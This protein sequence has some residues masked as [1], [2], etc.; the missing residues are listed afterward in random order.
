MDDRLILKV[1]TSTKNELSPFEQIE[2]KTATYAAADIAVGCAI[3]EEY[4][5][6]NSHNCRTYGIF[7]CDKCKA[8][9]KHVRDYLENGGSLV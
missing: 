7:I 4:T 8:A 1:D 9:I 5:S 2:S 3:C 6:M